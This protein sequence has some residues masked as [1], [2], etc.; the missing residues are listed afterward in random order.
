M[1]DLALILLSLVLL[2]ISGLL[3]TYMFYLERVISD[4][5]RLIHE[6]ETERQRLRS[7]LMK[8]ETRLERQEQR[9]KLAGLETDEVWAEVIEER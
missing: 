6:L 8:A 2:G 7:E 3:F 9:L 5:R 1:F 4:R